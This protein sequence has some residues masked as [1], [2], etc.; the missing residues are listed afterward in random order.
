M[1]LL[2]SK[3]IWCPCLPHHLICNT[4]CRCFHLAG[5]AW[6]NNPCCLYFY[7]SVFLQLIWTLVL[8]LLLNRVTS[9]IITGTRIQCNIRSAIPH[10]PLFC[11][12]F[13][14]QTWLLQLLRDFSDPMCIALY[15]KEKKKKKHICTLKEHCIRMALMAINHRMHNFDLKF[16]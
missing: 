4:V 7:F 10:P 2:T 13:L 11:L 16:H 5:L 9:K 1:P 12:F 8:F 14:V 15:K 3:N 6:V